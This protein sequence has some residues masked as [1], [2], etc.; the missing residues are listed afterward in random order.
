MHL[1]RQGRPLLVQFNLVVA[2]MLIPLI[3]ETWKS[4]FRRIK[5]LF[6]CRN[7]GLLARIAN[8]TFQAGDLEDAATE[9]WPSI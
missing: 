6:Q 2:W 5:P 4:S 9:R 1:M 7:L 8:I 3:L